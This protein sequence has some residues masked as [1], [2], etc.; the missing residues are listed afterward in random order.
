MEYPSI[1]LTLLA[2]F[3]CQQNDAFSKND[4]SIL[5]FYPSIRLYILVFVPVVHLIIIDNVNNELN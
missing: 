1:F 3:I 5:S 4:K 2:R